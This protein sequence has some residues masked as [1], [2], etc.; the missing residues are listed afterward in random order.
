MSSMLHLLTILLILPP[1]GARADGGESRSPLV[2][3][4]AA[5][6]N[7]DVNRLNTFEGGGLEQLCFDEARTACMCRVTAAIAKE[8]TGGRYGEPLWALDRSAL[9]TGDL[10]QVGTHRLPTPVHAT[11]H[12]TNGESPNLPAYHLTTTK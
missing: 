4:A 12:N 5:S 8:I 1:D 9:G 11:L 2:Q 6:E 3:V 7:P 10:K